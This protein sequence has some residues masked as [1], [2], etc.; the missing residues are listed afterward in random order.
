MCFSKTREILIIIFFETSQ[1]TILI[2]KM[3]IENTIIIE[4]NKQLQFDNFNNEN[5]MKNYI[6]YH[7]PIIDDEGD[8]E[9]TIISLL[10]KMLENQ[11]KKNIQLKKKL[12]FFFIVWNNLIV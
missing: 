5:D 9:N 1:T 7:Q 4:R 12:I 10:M 11:F 6:N 3:E 8:D 2:N